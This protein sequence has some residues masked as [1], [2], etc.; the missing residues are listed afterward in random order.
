M[1]KSVTLAARVDAD[2]DAELARLAT[3]TGRSKSWLIS[4]ALRSFVAN[5]QQFLAAAGKAGRSPGTREL[6]VAR[7]PYLVVYS[8]E[9]GAMTSDPVQI[10]ILRILHGAMSWPRREPS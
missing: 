5:K 2:L 1:S 8:A 7:Y 9:A 10:A 3:A 6:V 4:E